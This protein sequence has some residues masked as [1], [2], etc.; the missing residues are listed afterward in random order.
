MF[1]TNIIRLAIIVIMTF[2]VVSVYM[3]VNQKSYIYFPD[4]QNFDICPGF[5]D[6][7]KIR[8]GGTRMYYLPADLADMV[9]VYYHG[10]AGSACDRSFVKDGLKKQGF[11]LLFVEYAGYS[12][13]DRRPS[14]DLIMQDAKNANEFISRLGY[15]K[16]VLIGTS[17]GTAVAAY[18]QTL[19]RPEKMV[20]L[21][22]FDK[23]SEVG[24]IN[25]PF[26]PVNFL[27]TEE[28]D[29]A[30]WMKNYTGEVII[31]HGTDDEII[32]VK[33]AERLYNLIPSNDKKFITIEGATHNTLLDWPEVWRLIIEFVNSK[34]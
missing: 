33:L 4:N 17:L 28:Y 3:F 27:L 6:S 2:L 34:R 22:P 24:K 13:D 29:T 19:Q 10:N 31:I 15:K 23:L 1:R 7:E 32:P 25:Y 30:G 21:T 20:L 16:I 11:S 18:H 9:A 8:E 5:A 12:D 14:R 26:L